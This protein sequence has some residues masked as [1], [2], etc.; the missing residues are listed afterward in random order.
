LTT[1][2]PAFGPRLVS[3]PTGALRSALL[4]KPAR[5]IERAKPMPGEPGAVYDWALEQ[6]DTLRRTLEFFGAKTIVLEP[7]SQDPYDCAINDVAI[8]FEDGALLMRP[9]AMSR[10]GEVERLSAE[11]AR[12]DV[13]LAGHVAAPG[14]L[15]GG[16]LLLV[17]DT[18]F[19][20]KS[21]RGNDAGRQGFAQVARAHGYKIVEVAIG[22]AVP[23]L[24]CVVGAV[25]KDTV[26]LAPDQVDHAA[27][28]GFKTIV[29]DRGEELG[30]GVVVLGERHV[31][32]DIRYRTA[33]SKLRGAGV[34]VAAIDLY[35]Y[36][37]IGLTPSMLVLA[38]RRE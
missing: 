18:A 38:L 6:H 26:V 8:G 37:K 35:E 32:A 25:A 21:V 16:D 17:G 19:V 12:I 20:G 34:T 10:R 30:A 15:D 3:S 23:R 22:P 28:A 7:S 27:F 31:L 33:F 36:C 13:P 2:A 24:R 5:S 9:T 4:V 29:L 14:L 1:H 11:F